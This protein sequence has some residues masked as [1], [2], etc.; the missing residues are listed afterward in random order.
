[1]RCH[2]CDREMKP[3]QL[4]ANYCIALAVHAYLKSYPFSTTAQIATGI[5]YPYERVAPAMVKARE[6]LLIDVGGSEPTLDGYTRYRYV[7]T[8]LPEEYERLV[9][10]HKEVGQP[11]W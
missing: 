4:Q 9:R 7:A 5:K 3:G 8:D 2:V 1:M 6:L 10:N 11:R